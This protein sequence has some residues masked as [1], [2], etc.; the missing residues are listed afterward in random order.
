[1]AALSGRGSFWDTKTWEVERAAHAAARIAAIPAASRTH[2]IDE[3]QENFVGGQLTP[4]QF[5]GWLRR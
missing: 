2:D 4:D 1:V 3:H 5:P